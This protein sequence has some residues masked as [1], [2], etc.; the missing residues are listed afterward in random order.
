MPEPSHPRPVDPETLGFETIVYEKAPP[1]ATIRLNR[2]DVLNA[3]DFRMLREI[4]RACEDAS[5]DD[6]IRVRRRDRGGPR[7]LRRRRPPLVGGDARRPPAGVLEVVRRLQGH[8][9]PP[10]R[11]R[12]AD[13]RAGQRD[14]GR[15]RERAPDGLRP[16][17]HGGRRLHPSRRAR[18]RLRPGRR[19]D[20]VAAA[21]GRRPPRA[22]DRLPL[23]RDPGAR[24]P[25]SGASSTGRCPPPSSTAS[26][27]SGSRASRAS[28]RRRRGTRSSSSTSGA[29][30]PGTR[31]SATPGT[32]CRC[33]CSATR[34]RTRSGPS[35]SRG[36]ARIRVGSR[37]GRRG[38]HATRR[39]R[40]H[41]HVQPA[42]GLQR[43]QP[44]A[45]RR[46]PRGADRGGRS[47]DPVRRRHGRG[48]GLL[49]RSGPEGVRRG[50][51]L[52]RRR[53]R[54]DLPPERPA[55]PLA[56]EAGDR[57]RE[58]RRR[59]RGPLASPAPA[60][61]GSRRRPRRSCPG[62]SGSA[63][64]PTRAARGSSTGCSGFARAFEWM[65]TNRR[66]SAD[67]ALDW[68]LVSEVVDGGCVR[69]AGRRARRRVG[70]PSDARDRRGRSSCSSTRSTATLDEQ[71]AL[72]ARL[73]QE[74][75]GDGRLRAR[76]STPSS[77]SARPSS[78]APDRR[79]S[80]ADRGRRLPHGRRAVPHRDRRRRRR[81]RARRSSSA[82]AFA[83]E[84]L[85][86]VRR[87]LVFEPRGHADMYG[88]HVV[89]AERRRRRPRRRL[90]PQRGL[91]DRVR[92]RDDRARHL[93]ARRGR[94][95]A[96]RGR[97]TAS[98]STCRRAGS[99]RGRR[100]EDGR[101]RSVRFRNVPVVRVGAG[102]R[103]RRA[104]RRRRVRRRL[105]RLARGARRASRAAAAD[106]AR[107]ASSR[108]ALE[109]AHEIVHP[110]EPELRDVYGVIFW[111]DEG[112]EPAD[113]AERHRLRRR[114]GRPL[115]V[116]LAAPRRGSRCSTTRAG[117]RAATSSG[118]ARSSAP[119]SAGASS[120]TPRS[121]ADP[122]WSPRSRAAPTGRARASSCSTRTTRSAR[123]SCSGSRSVEVELA[124]EDLSRLPVR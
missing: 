68:G 13:D 24:R 88:C 104:R 75:V 90:L 19:C 8:A 101:V 52:D 46:P 94:R 3:F 78:P 64:C 72:E 23:R 77:R 42:R 59:G 11:A 54:G 103:G 18:A 50:V 81:S 86:H 80:G 112:D 36:A 61:S 92:P 116:R 96:A 79:A 98:S 67:E 102:R 17:R 85:D 47:R 28:C 32:G 41:D 83:L 51:G 107:A 95:R 70:G 14:R 9:R 4:A 89:A 106:R 123:A 30:W 113:A 49:R 99:R 22:R 27:T 26:S 109:A 76:A 16:R 38:A 73:Q 100:V 69:G 10:A 12:E 122:P 53:P 71:L 45:P 31:P 6:E 39:R 40:P 97:R 87:L 15:R 120:A 105:L 63:S 29:T 119:S 57:R 66:L 115:A 48:Q 37:R 33:R 56:R 118:T 58:R 35:S 25:R 60:T 74:S 93:G 7:V 111:Q 43:L 121:R 117:C 20:A 108:R 34:R 110:L 65:S 84:H 21:H 62:S 44:R 91:L 2:P 1:R 5:W 124:C 55:R 82:G 114:R